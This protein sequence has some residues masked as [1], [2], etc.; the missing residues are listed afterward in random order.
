[1]SYELDIESIGEMEIKVPSVEIQTAV[2]ELIE[3]HGYSFEEAM[4]VVKLQ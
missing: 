4:R 1:M 3:Q 2:V